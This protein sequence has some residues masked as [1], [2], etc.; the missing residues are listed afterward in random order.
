MIQ[1]FCQMRKL[2][3]SSSCSHG[4]QSPSW[5]ASCT[6][7]GQ[8]LQRRSGSQHEA[9][10]VG[11]QHYQQTSQHVRNGRALS[12]LFPVFYTC[13]SAPHHQHHSTWP[14]S[15][16]WGREGGTNRGTRVHFAS[17][18]PSW[19]RWVLYPVGCRQSAARMSRCMLISTRDLQVKIF[20]TNLFPWQLCA[21]AQSAL[22]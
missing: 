13:T 8:D 1:S 5:K 18:T 19:Y 9:A 22:P 17:S 2:A 20:R 14:G 15:A 10:A 12:K 21:V 3:R 16:K 6:W 4:T 11:P 7:Q